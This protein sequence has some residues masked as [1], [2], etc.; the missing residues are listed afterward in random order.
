[1]KK[2][3]LALTLLAGAPLFVQAADVQ[4]DLGSLK[5]KSGN[6]TLSIGDRDPRGYYWDGG[7]WRDPVYWDK[8][9]GN[10]KGNAHH[11]PPGQ[12]KKGNC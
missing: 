9:H 12:A 6:T 2:M 4:V 11:C 7:V 3:I 5:I 10:G 8:H 1:M